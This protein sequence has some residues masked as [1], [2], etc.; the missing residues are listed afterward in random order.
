MH[1]RP[2]FRVELNRGQ[3]V[4]GPSSLFS[5]IP[6]YLKFSN[7]FL[8][9]GYSFRLLLN[10]LVDN[11]ISVSCLLLLLLALLRGFFSGFSGFFAFPPKFLQFDL[12]TVDEG[13]LRWMYTANSYQ[14][15]YLFVHLLFTE[16]TLTRWNHL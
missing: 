5:H 6:T 14:F 12:K 1:E 10:Q 2:L 11:A 7:L 15:I 8:E 4:L 13:S 9:L 16:Y 3:I